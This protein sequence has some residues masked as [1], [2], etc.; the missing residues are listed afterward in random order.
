MTLNISNRSYPSAR[1]NLCRGLALLWFAVCLAG[2]RRSSQPATETPP[3]EP[4]RQAQLEPSPTSTEESSEALPHSEPTPAAE[5]IP[6]NPPTTTITE[7]PASISNL[8]LELPA[9]PVHPRR[10]DPRIR[11]IQEKQ[12]KFPTFAAYRRLAALYL[13]NKDYQSAVTTYRE[14]A[15]LYRRKGLIDAAIIEEGKAAQYDTSVRLFVDREATSPERERLYSGAPLEPL[16]GCYLGAFIDRDDQLSET[17]VDE[18]W[19][20]H[21]TP[22]EFL[23]H[24]HK[25]HASL[26]MYLGYGQKFPRRWIQDCKDNN[27][28]PHLAWEPK[29]LRDVRDD[30]YLRSFAAAC[31]D[32]DWPIFIRFAS[33]V[34]GD[35]TP[36]HDNPPLYRQK[37]RLVHQVLHRYAPRIATIW[38]V[39]NPP[40]NNI[41]AYYPGDAGCDWVGVNIYS[42]PF[43][44]NR[45][46]RPALGE[47][48][49]EL[50]DPI[51]K[52]YAS[53]KPIAI[54][55]YGASHMSVVD[56]VPRPE[57]AIN[58][59]SLLY[60]ALPRLYPRIKM[61][62]WFDMNSIRHPTPGK[63]LNDYTITENA[64][65]LATY[66]R[67]INTDYYLSAPE[68]LGDNRPSLPLPLTS[69]QRL[70]VLA[71]FS[72]WV[73][74]YVPRP[75][76][77]LKVGNKIIY[78]GRYP[79]AHIVD[80]DLR[81]HRNVAQPVT[82][83]VYD[84]QNRFIT[85]TATKVMV[86]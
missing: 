38:C 54:C 86:S 81:Q 49:L 84:D 40:L 82:V 52:R 7:A 4:P 23:K 62:N 25:P 85:S 66:R 35:W 71:R 21:R 43:H 44:E 9:P 72:V 80:A 29:D 77:Y 30:S 13:E 3:R 74:T 32:M 45:R 8:P 69:G 2:C 55:E 57:F 16:I 12:K 36:Y 64:E 22:G 17:Y 61:V 53:R 10:N 18:N 50:L 33:E 79:G 11:A 63:T 51:Y 1:I 76:V 46:D 59:M 42:V 68:R 5:A 24:T 6:E 14:E 26:F 83:Y 75:R 34:N 31:R 65:V 20:T 78:A 39:N 15:A 41:E 73:K 58:K 27:V 67:L 70:P 28:I 60:G 48:P 47:S 37:F 19:Q 56:K